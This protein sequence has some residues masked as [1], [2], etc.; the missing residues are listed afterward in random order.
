MVAELEGRSVVSFHPDLLAVR[1][2]PLAMQHMMNQDRMFRVRRDSLNS[3]LATLRESLGE[4]EAKKIGLMKML[5]AKRSQ[6]KILDEQILNMSDLVKQGF[7]S[8]SQLQEMQ[9]R[10]GQIQSEIADIDSQI[11]SLGKSLLGTQQKMITV[12]ES[13]KKE[14]EQN[15][16]QVML[17][18]NADAEKLK[19]LKAELDST[20]IKAPVKGQVIGMQYQTQG[21]VIPAGQRIMDIVPKDRELIIE[22]KIEPRL[23]DRI[24]VGQDVDVR[25]SNFADM[26]Q[27]KVEGKLESISGDSITNPNNQTSPS[28]STNQGQ[29]GEYYLARIKLSN[30]ALKILEGKNLQPGMQVQIIVLTGERSLLNYMLH[31]LIKRISAAMK[32]G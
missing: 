14:A 7:A 15:L 10:L 11:N 27:L 1:D 19:A 26:P 17:D 12:R 13:Y 6:A 24:L 22:A 32:E 16:S 31:P 8:M 23:I 30:E 20:I 18:V 29:P 2:D 5:E 25:F 4:V 28:S 9:I 21:A 3:E